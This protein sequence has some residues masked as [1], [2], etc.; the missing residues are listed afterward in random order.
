MIELAAFAVL[1]VAESVGVGSM[2]FARFVSL[3]ADDLA[4]V[5]AALKSAKARLDRMVEA[6]RLIEFWGPVRAAP[7]LIQLGLGRDMVASLLRADA[8]GALGFG[9]DELEAGE[10][11][12]RRLLALCVTVTAEGE[13]ISPKWLSVEPAGS[14]LRSVETERTEFS[15][16]LR[17]NCNLWANSQRS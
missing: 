3:S 9:C 10:A 13:V 11:M 1:G 7:A 2:C 4:Q 5:H 17:L 16:K 12:V 14:P 6:N 8:N 15:R